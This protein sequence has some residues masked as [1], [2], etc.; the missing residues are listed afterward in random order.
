MKDFL[1]V[2]TT[3]YDKIENKLKF[4]KDPVFLN[5]TLIE[6]VTPTMDI[7]IEGIKYKYFYVQMPSENFGCV[8]K[9]LDILFG[10]V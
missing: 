8:S 3:F 5:P 10:D 4:H 6:R 7:I 1:K 9:D 2:N